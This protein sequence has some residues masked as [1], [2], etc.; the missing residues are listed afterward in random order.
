ME[1]RNFNIEFYWIPL[2]HVEN[3]ELYPTNAKELLGCLGDGVRHFVYRENIKLP[4]K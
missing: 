1:G 3:I 2:E 4:E